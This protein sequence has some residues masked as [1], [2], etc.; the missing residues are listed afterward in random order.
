M[1]SVTIYEDPETGKHRLG[2]EIWELWEKT[3]DL[4]TTFD[5]YRTKNRFLGKVCGKTYIL[6]THI[7]NNIMYND[8]SEYQSR[9]DFLKT[10]PNQNEHLYNT[11]KIIDSVTVEN[12]GDIVNI[13][14]LF[15]ED[16][17]FTLQYKV[18]WDDENFTEFTVD[19]IEKYYIEEELKK[20][21]YWYN[22][23]PHYCEFLSNL[24][25]VEFLKRIK[26]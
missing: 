12:I 15:R 1:N 10:L 5:G 23:S 24:E 21:V 22:S 18:W 19:R 9:A 25:I 3:E 14:L 8:F 7:E 6:Y 2:E 13:S 26:E 4:G 11:S 16:E 17:T 20:P